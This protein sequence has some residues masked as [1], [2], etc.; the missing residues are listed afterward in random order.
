MYD[1][2]DVITKTAQSHER[3]RA[4]NLDPE[5][6]SGALLPRGFLPPPASVSSADWAFG[7]GSVARFGRSLQI[8]VLTRPAGKTAHEYGDTSNG[9]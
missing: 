2:T 7:R 4:L 8:R 5:I 6:G 3:A 1:A 9:T